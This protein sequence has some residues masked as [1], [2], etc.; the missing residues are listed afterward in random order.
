MDQRI[1]PQSVADEPADVSSGDLRGPSQPLAAWTAGSVGPSLLDSLR[2]LT[3]KQAATYVAAL[4]IIGTVYFALAKTGLTLA[5][6][7]PSATPIWPPTGFAL[8]VVLLWG[9]HVWPAIFLGASVANATA[10]GSLYTSLA[11]ATGNTLECVIGG[12]LVYAWAGGRAVFETPSGIAKFA[13]ISLFPSTVIS[14]TVGVVSLSVA[15]YAD[16]ASFVPVWA[17]WWLGDLAGAL[18]IAPVIVLWATSG[19]RESDRAR[20]LES[21]AV[22]IAAGV[23]GLVAFSPLLP[24]PEIKH[25]LAF[26]AVLPLLWAALRC[27]QRETATA[28]LVLSAFAIRGAIDGGGPFAQPTPNESFL[29][30]LAFMVS[31]SV[32]TL[33]LSADVAVRHRAETTVRYQEQDLRAILSQ[34]IAGI[35][36]STPPAATFSSISASARS[37]SGR[38]RSSCSAACRTSPTPTI[39]PTT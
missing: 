30:L 36:R 25:P 8:A 26:V 13:L 27:G 9:Y 10:Y 5:S 23:V 3:V 4:L 35:A 20:L 7:H 22:L 28:A 16:W 2:A 24:F 32:P 1:D 11:I 12:Y 33:A 31:A 37:C 15:G 34:S 19:R 18:V 29:L 17:T 21:G 39:C 14:A 38:S 6:A